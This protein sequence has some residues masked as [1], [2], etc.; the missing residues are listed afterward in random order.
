VQ[1]L[2]EKGIVSPIAA[3]LGM[4]AVQDAARID[5]PDAELLVVLLC[6]PGAREVQAALL[7]IEHQDSGAVL[8][9][10]SLTPPTP[11][12]AIREL[13]SD[14]VHGGPAPVPITAEELTALVLAA[15]RRAVEEEIALAHEAGSPDRKPRHSAA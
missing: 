4:L 14:G 8:T 13:L 7:G 12:A 9:A 1:R 15:A 10:C 11:I 6:R 2:A 5:G 3:G